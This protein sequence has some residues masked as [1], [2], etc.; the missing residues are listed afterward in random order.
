MEL[1][2]SG[3]KFD[4]YIIDSVLSN[5]YSYR[6][7]YRVIRENDHPGVLVVY[8]MDAYNGL[9]YPIYGMR[10]PSEFY[11]AYFLQKQV[12]PEVFDVGENH[13]Y[14]N[15]CWMCQDFVFGL[16][17]DCFMTIHPESS[18]DKMK[19]LAA[20][21]CKMM[22]D[23]NRLVPDCGHFN[24]T[25]NNIIITV[26]EKGEK[27]PVLIGYRHSCF[28]EAVDVSHPENSAGLLY[29]S[30]EMLTGNYSSSC[31]VYAMGVIFSEMFMGENP[32]HCK[33]EKDQSFTGSKRRLA[34]LRRRKL[35]VKGVP[36]EV[37][38]VLL[39]ALQSK[40]RRF[41]NLDE[42]AN[43]LM[44]ALGCE[45]LE[46]DQEE[47]VVPI[48]LDDMKKQSKQDEGKE[49][50]GDEDE[51]LMDFQPD[52]MG[53]PKARAKM[54]KKKGSGFAAVAGMEQLKSDLTQNFINVLRY[55]DMAKAYGIQPPNG[56]LLYGPPGCGKSY[57]ASRLAEEVGINASFVRPSDLG[58]T[59]IHG[60]QSMIADLFNKA[61]KNAPT[62]LVF[63]EMDALVPSRSKTTDNVSLS[64]EVNEFLTQLE[65]CSQRGIFVVG[66]TNRIEQIDP[67]VLR[68]GRIEEVVYVPLP[69][70]ANRQA[71]LKMELNGKPC[72]SDIDYERLADLTERFTMSDV[73]YA[74]KK[75]CRLAFDKAVTQGIG[76]HSKIDM[77]LMEKAISSTAP[78]VDLKAEKEFEQQR[79]S[80]EGRKMAKSV[81][82]HT[83]GFRTAR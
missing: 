76:L 21:M 35:K 9:C 11:F 60:S 31:D 83:I 65:S 17:L 58:S 24:I 26:D 32:W 63:D 78:S 41:A 75:A 61:E 52:E 79:Q 8:D 82:S 1:L 39:C 2:V 29:K 55:S 27:T 33:W 18:Y 20:K 68:T 48:T 72:E 81:Q 70:R 13:R 43:A 23:F 74:V 73:S 6:T 12:G 37:E 4:D 14:G 59:Y 56:M 64:S 5:S 38:E 40:T 42:F 71:L 57:L 66:T 16:T 45:V 51:D 62:I 69:D 3:K 34:I 15:F 50:D 53:R 49:S 19:D 80:Y 77:A 67:A 36:K 30:P 25:P 47:H 10:M 46:S 44:N 22:M 28:A 54:G 7:V